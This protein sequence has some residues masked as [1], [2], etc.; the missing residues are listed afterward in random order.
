V[1]SHVFDNDGVLIRS[2]S[3]KAN[4]YRTVAAQWG[5]H[6]A[7][8][9]VVLQAELG[10]LSRRDKWARIFTEIIGVEPVGPQFDAAV[11]HCSSLI[12]AGVLRAPKVPGAVSF[13]RS[14][15][16]PIVVSGVRHPELGAVLDAHGFG[17]LPSFGG[18]KS[19][20]LP[21]LVA[22]G[23]IKLPAVYYGDTRDDWLAATAAG[24]D[25]VLVTCDTH[26]LAWVDEYEGA[27]VS[28]FA[29]STPYGRRS[30][31]NQVQVQHRRV[32]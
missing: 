2:N 8:A 23:I 31:G 32:R 15:V 1:I 14:C 11:H 13:V 5:A 3:V 25:F 16:N 9:A 10:S 6:I 24:L 7:D 21:E 29:G 19:D 4:A 28:T 22:N 20:M 17:D 18:T 30:D 12:T 27:H 26:W